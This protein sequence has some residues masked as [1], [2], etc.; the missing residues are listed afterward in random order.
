LPLHF[1]QA[2]AFPKKPASFISFSG[3]FPSA[4]LGLLQWK[5]PFS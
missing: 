2:S 1:S 3:G 4:G 5:Q